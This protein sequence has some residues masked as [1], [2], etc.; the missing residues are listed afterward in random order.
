MT[1]APFAVANLPEN[2]DMVLRIFIDKYL[3]E[4]FV[5]DC[6]AIVAAHMDYAAAN[7]LKAYTFGGPTRLQKV[8]IWKLKP[9]NQGFLEARQNRI[10]E[11]ETE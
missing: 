2:E 4:V 1:E 7:G 6:Q 11:C 9:T 8:E 5:N 3:V 10:W